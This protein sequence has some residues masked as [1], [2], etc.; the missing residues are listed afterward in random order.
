VNFTFLG[1]TLNKKKD[2]V[3]STRSRIVK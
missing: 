1:H 2:F 3:V